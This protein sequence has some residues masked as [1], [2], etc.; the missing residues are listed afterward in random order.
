MALWRGYH[1]HLVNEEYRRMKKIAV[2][3]DTDSSLPVDVAA[4]YGIRQVPIT[5]QFGD[6][7]YASGVDI[8]DATLFAKVDRLKKLPTTSAPSPGAFANAYQAAFDEGA[9]GVVVVCVSSKI[10]ATY[11]SAI[12]ASEQFPGRPIR[13]ID[14]LSVSM[15]QG[16]MT[17]AA[18]EA[19][20]KGADLE[21]TVSAAQALQGRLHLFAVLS[22][23]RY[24]AMSGRVGKIAAGM[25]DTLNI[26]PILTMDDGKL[27]LLEKVRTRKKAVE[28]ML[29]L[30]AA[31]VQSRGL[32]RAAL[33]HITDAQGAAD[34]GAHLRARLNISGEMLLTEFT[35]GLSVH[36]GSGVVGTVLVTK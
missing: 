29:D 8:D 35:P 21:Q 26:K 14:S 25:A 18:A 27:V 5:I 15:G 24:L 7:S 3:T 20:S 34:F 22:T 19:A 10:S 28:R 33:I 13:V 30:S 6:E 31:A 12:S 4:R 17:L 9:E 23:L 16:F 11:Q 1:F 32:D 2:V 36:A